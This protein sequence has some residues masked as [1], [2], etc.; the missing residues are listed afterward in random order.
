MAG[1]ILSRSLTMGNGSPA[2]RRARGADVAAGGAAGTVILAPPPDTVILAPPRKLCSLR[3]WSHAT[4]TGR[5]SPSTAITV[6]M[7]S[8]LHAR[9]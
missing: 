3:Q 9:Q 4:R 5:P 7:R 2:V 6:C 1:A 8:N